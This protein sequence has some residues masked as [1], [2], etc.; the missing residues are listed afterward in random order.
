M[1][2][3]IRMAVRVDFSDGSQHE[4]EVRDGDAVDAPAGM[5]LW[6]AAVVSTAMRE[7]ITRELACT[8]ALDAAVSKLSRVRDWAEHMRDLESGALPGDRWETGFLGAVAGVLRILDA[9]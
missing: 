9:P 8:M 5:V 6:P 2:V 1:S 3:P 4:Y 7:Q